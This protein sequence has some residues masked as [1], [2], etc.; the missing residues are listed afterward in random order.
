MGK[1]EALELEM[2]DD[3]IN[4]L[5]TAALRTS[6]FVNGLLRD[7]HR[8]E[9]AR[10]FTASAVL[11]TVYSLHEQLSGSCTCERCGAEKMQLASIIGSRALAALAAM[12]T[13][14]KKEG[15]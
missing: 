8:D 15:E 14:P 1:R 10:E 12:S 5:A 2:T 3:K 4:D 13:T 9:V 6:K 7:T 11:L